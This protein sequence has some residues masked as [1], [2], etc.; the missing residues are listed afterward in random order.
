MLEAR[1]LRKA[2]GEFLAVDDVSLALAPGEILGL[3]GPNGAGK[4]TILHMLLGL[5]TPTAG[6]IRIFGMDLT[7]D[8]SRILQRLNFS[9]SYVS[10]PYTLSVR[11]NLEVF[12]RLYAVK[13]LDARIDEILDLLHLE[14]LAKSQTRALSS[15]QL[16]RLHLAKAL[17]NQPELLFLDEPTASLDPDTADQIRHLLK[18]LRDETR[19]SILY[20]SHNMAEMQ[21]M[22]DRVLFLNRGRELATGT[23]EDLL[24]RFDAPDLEALFLKIAR[25]N[26]AP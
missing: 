12:G 3:L 20:T 7:R 9:S 6:S 4:T 1:K 14:P 15:G 21:D 19:L 5:I 26:L 11:E 2:F 22:S 18:R 10:L 23:P 24:R 17:L 8:R 25:G 13:P 16:T